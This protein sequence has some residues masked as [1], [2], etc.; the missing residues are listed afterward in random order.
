MNWWFWV[1][2]KL[3]FNLL[4]A[5]RQEEVLEQQADEDRPDPSADVSDH[6]EHGGRAAQ[7]SLN[8]YISSVDVSL[9]LYFSLTT[10][11]EKLH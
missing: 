4:P 10:T 7:Q 9:A 3:N 6:Q 8:S 5:G 11:V 1:E 2:H